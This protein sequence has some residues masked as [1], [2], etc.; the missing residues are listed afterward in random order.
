MIAVPDDV[1]HHHRRRRLRTLMLPALVALALIAA[2]TT[3]PHVSSDAALLTKLALEKGS[4]FNGIAD[5]SPGDCVGITS[6]DSSTCDTSLC[7]GLSLDDAK[8]CNAVDLDCKGAATLNAKLCI[9]SFCKAW[10]SESAAYCSM[11]DG[12]CKALARWDETLCK[13]NVCKSIITEDTG[14]CHLESPPPSTPPPTL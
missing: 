2:R 10:A 4:M 6:G 11:G 8:H 13:S 5:L 12:D 9:S 7:R 14:L 1:L 3:G